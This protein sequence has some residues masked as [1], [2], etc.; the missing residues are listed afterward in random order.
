MI[1]PNF[2]DHDSTIQLPD[3]VGMRRNVYWLDHDNL[4]AGNQAE[5]YHRK[6][7]S[8]NWEVD[9]VHAL[10]RHVIRQGVYAS[11]DIAVLTPYTRQLQKLQAVMRNDFEIVVSNRDQDAL[12]KDGFIAQEP[13]EDQDTVGQDNKRKPLEKKKLSDLL[14]VATVDNFQGEEA[15]IIIVTLVQSNREQSGR[16]GFSRL[17][18]TSTFC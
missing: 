18:I 12:A 1:Y 8:N 6:S 17:Q 3:V 16:L 9:M 2:I 7:K 14:R 13:S 4:E 15:K 11:S 10:V 5:I